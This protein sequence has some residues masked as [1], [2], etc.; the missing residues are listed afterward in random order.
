M[1][2]RV[3]EMD[4]RVEKAVDGLLARG[5]R[6]GFLTTAEVQQEL[7]EAKASGPAFEHAVEAARREGIDV[8]EGGADRYEPDP[9]RTMVLLEDSVT[10]YLNEIG[11]YPLLTPRQEV[12]LA[13]AAESGRKAAARLAELEAGEAHSVKERMT[14]ARAVRRGEEAARRLVE[15]N[16]RLVVSVVKR[17]AGNGLPLLDLIQE[18]NIGLMEAV[19]KFD[20]RK[21][22]RFAT[23]GGWWI[24]QK[25]ARAVA[26]K[27]RAIRVPT[28]MVETIYQLNSARRHL[29][30]ELGRDPTAEEVALEM[31]LPPARVVEITKLAQD[32]VSLDVP[33]GEEKEST[34]GD[35]VPDRGADA[36]DK[37]SLRLLQEYVALV[38]D[39]LTER[40]RRLVLLRFGLEGGRAFSL[41][42]LS[43][44]FGLTKERIRQ[45]ER[46]ALVKL[47]NHGDR[48]RL[49][50]YLREA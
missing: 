40:E 49:E 44:H 10:M 15:S 3:E 13:V 33:V 48:R 18:G 34:L 36:A 4:P 32:P 8:M 39:G 35:F 43:R 7:E 2:P 28:H 21:G 9:R 11:R 38:L 1:E 37:A 22:F 19:E 45:M 20:H 23:Y 41:D 42:E 26:D 24:R 12:D 31:D 6:R 30:Q 25:V 14:L 50:G 46:R 17:Y 29:H 27:G 5:R 16:L 47:R